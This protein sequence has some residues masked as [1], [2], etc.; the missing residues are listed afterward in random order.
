MSK[1]RLHKLFRLFS[2][3]RNHIVS[4]LCFFCILTASTARAQQSNVSGTV[5]DGSGK[6]VPSASVVV[7]GTSRGTTSDDNGKFS[8]SAA[9]GDIL[10][11]SGVGF[12]SREMSVGSQRNLAISL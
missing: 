9:S 12:D 10:V 8:I 5:T 7:K 3:H 1:S 6:P 4:I 11:I 2:F